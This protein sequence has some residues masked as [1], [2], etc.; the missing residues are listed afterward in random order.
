MTPPQPGPSSSRAGA[1][2]DHVIAHDGELAELIRSTDWSHTSLG[3][4]ESWPALLRAVLRVT[5]ANRHPMAV[6]WGRDGVHLYNE[7]FR[8]L[9]GDKHPG[10]LGR[11]GADV[12]AETWR[13]LGPVARGILDGGPATRSEHVLFPVNRGGFVE[14]TYFSFSCSPIPLDGG[15]IGGVLVTARETTV[16][17]Q[18]DRELQTLRDLCAARSTTI[19]EALAKAARVLSGNDADFPFVLLYE[20]EEEGTRV[21]L[22]GSA[23]MEG[24]QGQAAA[25][26]L[27]FDGDSPWPFG[28]SCRAEGPVVVADLQ[29]RVGPM[30]GGRWGKSP[31]R[32]AVVCLACPGP[33]QPYGFLVSGVSPLRGLD[34]RYVAL[35]SLTAGAVAA[36]IANALAYDEERRR[37]EDRAELERAKTAFFSNVSHEFRSPLT[38]ILGPLEEA[39]AAEPPLPQPIRRCVEVAHRNGLR[40]LKVINTL[41]DFARIEVGRSAP[42][43]EAVDLAAFTAELASVFRP[44]LENAGIA[45]VVDT[46]PLQGDVY[47]DSEMW[48][49]IVLNLVFHALK[50]T[51]EGEI[52]I[53][54]RSLDGAVE[55][56]VADTGL[57]IPEDQLQSLFQGSR[58]HGV[59]LDLVQELVR[60]HGGTIRAES[61]EG[62]GTVFRVTLRKGKEH[63]PP[64]RIR[65]S[66]S[67]ARA[68]VTA[69]VVEE[70]R[71]WIEDARSAP[72]SS[73]PIGTRLMMPTPGSERVLLAEDNADMRAY[74]QRLLGRH[75]TVEAFADGRPALAR[76]KEKPP[77]LLVSDVVMPGIDGFGL[78]RELRADP[79]TRAVPVILLSARADEQERAESLAAGADDYLMKPFSARELMARVSSNLKLSRF[80]REAE[81]GQRFLAEASALLASSLDYETTLRSVARLAVP[82]L[83]DWCAFFVREENGASGRLTVVHSDPEKARQA[84]NLFQRFPLSPD[85]SWAFPKVLRT[86]Q[87][88]LI[89]EIT[90]DL[91]RLA[92]PAPEFLAFLRSLGLRSSLSVPL[93]AGGKTLGA[94]SLA[95]SDSNRRLGPSDLSL[96]QELGLRA[97]MAIEN[98]RLYREV[99]REAAERARA[100]EEIR[101]SYVL[102][103]G[104]IDTATDV[105]FEKDL[106]GRYLLGNSSLASFFRRPLDEVIGKSDA[107]LLTP[108]VA[109]RLRD[110]DLRVVEEGRPQAIEERVLSPD[111]EARV[112]HSIKI[113][114]RD[115]DGKAFGL[116]GV[117]RDVTE[118]K[119]A[120]ALARE[121]TA[122]TLRRREALLELTK[123]DPFDFEGA[124]RNITE[125][126]AR[127][128]EVERVSVW[129][130]NEGHT[131]IVCE[132]LYRRTERDHGRGLRL[133]AQRYPR[134]FKA[135]GES[136]V[137]AAV[138]ARRDPQTSEFAPG[139]LEPLGITSMMDVPVRLQGDLIGV[140]CHEHVGPPRPWA[141][142]DEVFAS[143]IADVVSLT[144]T[145]RKRREAEEG[146]RKLN[147]S[148]EREVARRTAQLQETVTELE[149]FT[150]T[151]AHDLRSPLRGIYRY[152]DALREEFAGKPLDETGREYTDRIARA[153]KRMDDLIGGLLGYSR[154]ARVEVASSSLDVE[155]VYREAAAGVEGDL[156]D[157][158]AA[159]RFEGPP[160]RVRG[161]RLLLSQVLANYLTNAVK[162]VPPGRPPR[163]RVYVETRGEKIRVTVE[164]N[165]MGFPPAS[166]DKLFQIF[167]RL[168][169]GKDYPGM[170]M[171]LA[172]A[173]KAAQRM[174]GE[175]GA[176]CVPG[177][178][179]RFWVDLPKGDAP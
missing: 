162:F 10:A 11:S 37:A 19:H 155:S 176:E 161:D 5:L 170:G 108:D 175:V 16:E 135:L 179:S 153:A 159:A 32:A 99:Q 47:V 38:L 168:G 96:V 34:D 77:D 43:F 71:A 46:P 31:D 49:K 158:R 1:S 144:M 160:A 137:V 101:R 48:E 164:D 50:Y 130:F 18:D 97:G 126:D 28:E 145:A 134:Y 8:A 177:E 94:L 125:T 112:F 141:L 54:L 95:T 33:G 165:G 84:E 113:P 56:E 63:L 53:R 106:E 13:I 75:W 73:R 87:P 40:L 72:S 22:A 128:L 92:A 82:R 62:S 70:A 64:R 172:I 7:A 14:E 57:G 83:G 27:P 24:Y 114:L 41:L 21:R 26:E 76:A 166:R 121:G 42:A 117:S 129:L 136:R 150:Y 9:L 143:S 81:A 60:L 111:G 6:W 68:V 23:G 78:L 148:L 25:P 142:E 67:G 154:L 132:D 147:E 119:R 163:V 35:F 127:I 65:P 89:V 152:S 103:K 124:L 109:S 30:P 36:G 44:A 86:G 93:R 52:A 105:I 149:G 146:I 51:F 98:T 167:E 85:L 123:M 59:G 131:A 110:N 157:R 39:L 138:D 3:P 156:R 79:S 91:L 173:K 116:V 107:D 122:R 74:I 140:V 61:R 2:R 17:V 88:E 100:E 171:G 104:V 133:E 66:K 45:L 4:V 139:Y 80:R 115:A 58:S 12:W 90:D 15:E 55:L 118:Q 169:V 69:A 178:G 120:E 151:V 20:V 29:R 174:G 102:L